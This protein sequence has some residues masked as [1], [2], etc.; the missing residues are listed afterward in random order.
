MY[1]RFDLVMKENLHLIS[2][3]PFDLTRSWTA[4]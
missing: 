4:S 1:L 3:D 2:L